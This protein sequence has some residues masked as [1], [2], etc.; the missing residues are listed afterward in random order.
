LEA[1]LAVVIVGCR[2]LRGSYASADERRTSLL[3]T[4]GVLFAA[5][6]VAYILFCV[7]SLIVGLLTPSAYSQYPQGSSSGSFSKMVRWSIACL[8]AM[9]GFHL[10]TLRPPPDTNKMFWFTVFGAGAAYC[11]AHTILGLLLVAGA[12]VFLLRVIGPTAQPYVSDWL[13]KRRQ[14][15]VIDTTSKNRDRQI[16]DL[17]RQMQWTANSGAPPGH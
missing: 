11:L 13:A 4:A 5:S 10:A 17:R 15:A 2:G 1:G 3:R 14:Q 12:A 16:S 9:V 7:I 6:I 8:G